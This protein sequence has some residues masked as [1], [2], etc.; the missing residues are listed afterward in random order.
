MMTTLAVLCCAAMLASTVASLRVE[1]QFGAS[2][3]APLPANWSVVLPSAGSWSGGSNLT[4]TVLAE[5]GTTGRV[6]VVG[7]PK[8]YF[9]VHCAGCAAAQRCPGVVETV[10]VQAKINGCRYATNGGPFSESTGSCVTPIITNGTVMNN[11]S[12]GTYQCIGMFRNGSWVLGYIDPTL[13][14]DVRELMCGFSMLVVDGEALTFQNPEI[15][16]RTA[17]GIDEQGA[18][19]TLVAEGSEVVYTGLTL[20]QTSQWMRGLGARY[21]I[22]MDG[23]GSSTSYWMDN[24]GV[25]GC[26]TCVDQP[27]CC[28]RSVTTIMCVLPDHE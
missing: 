26:P 3:S 6:A 28:L 1:A 20:N 12:Q 17:F 25:Q 14:P 8:S 11:E 13:Y 9:N 2:V 19:I 7:N 27:Y 15:A 4:Y 10:E 22:N 18:L 16:P 5:Y 24:G 21:A 23:G